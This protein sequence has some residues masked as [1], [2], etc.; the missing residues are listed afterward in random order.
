[1]WG[2]S[3]DQFFAS[4]RLHQQIFMSCQ[5]VVRASFFANNSVHL[6]GNATGNGKHCVTGVYIG[7]TKTCVPFVPTCVGQKKKDTLK[8]IIRGPTLGCR[9][10]GK[11]QGTGHYLRWTPH[12]VIVAIRDNKD[13]I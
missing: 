10:L 5:K 4:A 2:S 1:M 8:H 9:V 11:E 12:P 13:Y 7:T 3:F 6:P